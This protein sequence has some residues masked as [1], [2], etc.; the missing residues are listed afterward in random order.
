MKKSIR[1]YT[2]KLLKKADRN[3]EE[4]VKGQF[5]FGVYK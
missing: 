1:T 2:P 4:V 5:G 3:I